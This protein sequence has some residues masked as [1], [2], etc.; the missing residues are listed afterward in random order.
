MT[1]VTV[2]FCFDERILLGA[3][4]SILSLIDHAAASTHYDLH[5]F[6]PGFGRD[7]IDALGS[8]LKGTRHS[9]SF[10]EIRPERFKNAPKNRG[11]WTEVVYF[12][13]LASEIL[14]GINRAIYSDVDV[15]FKRDLAEV[16]SVDLSESEWA[17]VAA[18]ANRPDYVLHKHFP[19]NT[20]PFTYFSG[21]MVMNLALMRQNSAVERYFK[22]IESHRSEL[23]FFDLDILNIATP[24]IVRLPFDFVVLEDI[25]ESDE[26][27][28]TKDFRFLRTIYSEAELRLAREHAAIIHFAGPR[29]KPWQRLDV[30]LYYAETAGRLPGR[31]RGITARDFRKRIFERKGRKLLTTRMPKLWLRWFEFL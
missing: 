30:P 7:A 21:F 11:S 18:E 24:K 29:G 9:I 2:V 12:R 5:I 31:L 6:H 22:T 25:Y 13:L 23:K 15:F 4:V 26:I 17:G 20:K 3:G 10:H 8:L 16:F 28:Q 19:A 27:S 14:T 1:E